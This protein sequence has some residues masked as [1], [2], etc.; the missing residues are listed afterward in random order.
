MVS[1]NFIPWVGGRL[2][3]WLRARQERR[4][5]N[6]INHELLELYGRITTEHPQLSNRERFNKLVMMRNHCDEDEAYAVLHRAEDNYAAWPI[7]RELTLC[8]V[9]HYLSVRE[10]LAEQKDELWVRENISANLKRMVPHKLCQLHMKQP[11]TSERRKYP[12][13]MYR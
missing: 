8:D 4:I 2:K 11:Y 9:I 13:A 6:E 5:V 10:Y 12:R 7:E 3:E 1:N